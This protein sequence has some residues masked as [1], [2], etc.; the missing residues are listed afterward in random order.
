MK[1]TLQLF[2]P[3]EGGAE[4]LKLHDAIPPFSMIEDLIHGI[5]ACTLVKMAYS[6]LLQVNPG[7]NPLLT[8]PMRV[9]ALLLS[10]TVRGPPLSPWVKQLIN[11]P[12][13]FKKYRAWSCFC[14]CS[15]C[16]HDQALINTLSVCHF[17]DTFAA[18]NDG[19]LSLLK[20]FSGSVVNSSLP[21][22][23][24]NVGLNQIWTI[25][26]SHRRLVHSGQQSLNCCLA[27]KQDYKQ[28]GLPSPLKI[29]SG[30]NG[31]LQGHPYLVSATQYHLYSLCSPHEWWPWRPWSAS[32]LSKIVTDDGVQYSHLFGSL[33]FLLS[34]RPSTI[35][36]LRAG[37]TFEEK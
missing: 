17:L 12:R 28:R 10:A 9:W 4:K 37:S 29:T 1:T 36:K 5:R 7:V 2:G 6:S 16:T 11:F 15:L 18:W 31:M 25:L 23:W 32:Y 33:S 35:E 21:P 20:L 24:D 22:A 34:W 3:S 14:S 13:D 26:F 30:V 27:D 19:N 8:I